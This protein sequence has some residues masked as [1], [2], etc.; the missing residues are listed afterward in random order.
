MK[1]FIINI[2][3]FILPIIL[4]GYFLDKIISFYLRKSNLFA[5]REY[6]TWNDV[7]DGKLE[8]EIYVYGSSRAW[9]HIN[10]QIL[11]DSLDCSVYNLGIDGQTFNMQYLRHSLALKYNAKPKTIIHSLDIHTLVRGNLHNKDQ[12]LPYMLLN[13]TFYKHMSKY[14]GYSYFDYKV[15]LI[16]YYGN[17]QSLKTVL[18]M[19]VLPQRNLVE[20]VKG[21]K[22]QNISWNTDFDKAKKTI[23]K[24]RVEPDSLTLRLFEKYLKDCKEQNIE[25]VLVY[26]PYYI[27]GQQFIENQQ[28]IISIYHELAKKYE[29]AFYNFIN[30]EICYKKDYFYNAS[31]LN[32]KGSELFTKKLS[33]IIKNEINILKKTENCITK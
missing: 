21:Y 24:Y 30:D 26:S 22:G 18:K 14:E 5:Q 3:L 27:E 10:P 17:F 28:Q 23:K 2:L 31:H 20:R 33:S 6:S 4:S 1:R 8:A 29:V 16:R 12:F 9:V 13:D 11:K 32:I 7:L 19:I 15:P 25:V